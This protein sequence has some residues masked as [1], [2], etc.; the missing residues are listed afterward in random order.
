MVLKAASP[1][2]LFDLDNTLHDA[3]PHIF[4]HLNRA[5]VA[6]IRD[7]LGVD[8][9]AATRIRQDYWQRYG[10][11]LLGLMRHHGT[12]PQ[13]F[14]WHTHQFPDLKHMLVLERG[15]RAML[16]R[17]PGRKIVFSNAPLHYSEAVLELA[18]IDACFDAVYSIERIRFQPKPAIGGFRHLLRSERLPAHRCIMVEDTLANLQ[19]AKRLGMQTV[20]V[21]GSTRQPSFVDL[22]LV[23]ILDLPRGLQHLSIGELL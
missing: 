3:S 16:L 13:H 7:H 11:T 22:R 9:Q 19:T 14:L 4:P 5:M 1:V 21:C 15:L 18:G 6:Y 23:S 10:A 17:L 2:W 20:W 12:D 8:E